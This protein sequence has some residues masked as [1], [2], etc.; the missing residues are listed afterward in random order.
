MANCANHRIKNLLMAACATLALMPAAASA[1][2]TLPAEPAAVPTD[3]SD[4]PA[5]QEI[6]VTGSRLGRTSFNSPTPVNVVGQERVQNLNINSVGDALNQIPSFR[7]I[8]TPATSSFRVS[9]SIA[10][11]SLDL[12]GLGTT[13][14]LTLINGA[15]NVPSGDDNTFDLNSIPSIM[16][17]R[18]EVVTG[19]AS[20]AYG[21]DAVAGVVNL[22]LD[23]R[24]TGI[25]GEVNSGISQQGDAANY[26]GA[27]MGGAEF[28]GGRGH[29]VLGGEYQ[30]EGGVGDYNNRKWSARYHSYVPNPFFNTNPALSN[31]LPANVATDGTLY[32]LTPGGVI[33]TGSAPLQGMQFDNNGN[34]VPFQFGSLFNRQRPSS[35]MVGGDPNVR[36]LYGFNRT[37]LVVPSE[38]WAIL[39]NAEY[40]LTDAIAATAEV[41]YARVIGGITSGATNSDQNGAIRINRDNAYLSAATAAAMDAAKV[42]F[43]PV[44]RSNAELG[45]TDYIT[46]NT[47]LRAHFGL[48]GG[49]GGNWKWDAF[50]HYGRTKGREDGVRGRFEQRWKDSIDAV[51]VTTANRGTSGLPI[52]SIVCRTTLTSPTNGCVPANVMGE[53]KVSPEAVAWVT[54]PQFQTRKFTQH[55]TGANLRGDLFDAWAGPVGVAAGVEYRVNTAVGDNDPNSKAAVFQT[56]NSTVLPQIRQKVTE[57]YLEANLPIFKDFALGKSLEID[58]AVR[59]T[60]YSLSGNATTWKV[61]AAWEINDEYM[62]RVTRS[63]DIRAPTPVE[64]N[65]NVRTQAMTL[66]DPKLGIQYVVPSLVGGKSDLSLERG[67]TFT[68][69][70]VFKPNWFPRFRLSVDYYNIKVGNAIDIVSIPVAMQL[71][72]NG[73][74]GICV[75]GTDAQGNAD[76]VLQLFATYQ[77]V[78][79]LRAKGIEVVSNYSFDLADLAKSFSG[80]MNF[81]LNGTYTQTL[82]TTL[83]GGAT[84]EFSNVTGNAGSVLAILG[85]PKYRLDGVITYEQPS[86]SITTQLRYIPHGLVSRT[87][88]G[89]QDEGYNIS[90]PT[91]INDNRIAARFYVNLNGQLTVLNEGRHKVQVFAGINNLFDK[92]PPSNL[93]FT[94]N[95]LYFDPIGR[96]FKFGVRASY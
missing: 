69:G 37:P 46:H 81:T 49:L 76:R 22:I 80:T 5:D 35:L 41:S 59:R 94:G 12:R 39:G 15:R 26:Y 25:K 60:H 72:R 7:P 62:V 85:V 31:G 36:D 55:H 84:N 21:A 44:S 28:G 93:R 67:D 30:K 18:S 65:P 13:R 90:L 71:C 75:T 16:I 20:A 40:Q 87:F 10:A 11:R 96:A 74:P 79:Q 19:G 27:L 82:R 17:A 34:L 8:T 52:G 3:A 6:V 51:R 54:G 4:R 66:A 9:G 23:T 95:G 92:D 73:T 91:S 33:S 1:Q 63:R 43:I 48:K 45:G 29:V 2:A 83:P 24:F 70:A 58:G 57:G 38:H 77:N 53:G 78:A 42:T 32:V 68:V 88:I 61:G 50:Y 56:I 47:T 64:L 89:P 86:Y 14:T